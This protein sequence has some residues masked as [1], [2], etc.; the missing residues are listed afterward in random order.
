MALAQII[1]GDGKLIS[2]E[3]LVRP[4]NVAWFGSFKK[5]EETTVTEVR[6][7]SALTEGAA[8]TGSAA[9]QP[10]PPETGKYSFLVTEQS[11]ETGAFK[12]TRTQVTTSIAEV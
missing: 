9:P 2:R 3:P 12:L 5:Y 4:Y 1:T 6:E 11:R 7:W 8:V 10:V